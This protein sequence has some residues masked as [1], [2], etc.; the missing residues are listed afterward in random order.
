[1]FQGTE[2]TTKI[3][4]YIGSGLPVVTTRLYGAFD[5]IEKNKFGFLVHSSK[6]WYMAIKK[7]LLDKNFYKIYSVN[8][9]NFAK[10]Y[11]EE[12]VLTPVFDK[13]FQDF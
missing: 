7:L 1:M 12:K 11:D 10:N 8:A 6:E 13:I 5:I 4:E 3:V 2:L 9:L